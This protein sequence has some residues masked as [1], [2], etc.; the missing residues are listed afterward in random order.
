MS[1]QIE[2]SKEQINMWIRK[3]VP[4]KDFFFID[5]S[6]LTDLEEYLADVLLI[7]REEFFHHSSYKQIDLINSFMYWNISNKA[8]NVIVADS[9]WVTKLPLLKRKRILQAQSNMRRGLVL[10]I[11]SLSFTKSVPK[12]YVVSKNEEFFL[13]LQ[14]DMW[15][16]MSYELKESLLCSYAKRWDNGS[17][18]EVPE[19]TPLHI[20]K[21][22]NK[23]ST[24]SGSNCLSS[25]LFAVTKQD[26]V[27][28][29]WVHQKTFELALERVGYSLI[30]SVEGISNGDVITWVNPK[31]VIQHASYH[32]SNH[33][34]FNKDGQTFFNP[35][36]VTHLNQLIE[37]W[38]EY[39]M[40]IYRKKII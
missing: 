11:D 25:T 22:T 7:P 18:F 37:E 34:F 5:E 33:L 36:K 24:I 15:G 40:N 1:I 23:F 6:A 12:E 10:P 38:K 17:C 27:I 9:Q 31:N 28:K 29:E 14:Q 13:V 30:K 39:E 32:I 20:K 2:P 21:Y 3:F 16:N 8:N 26:W 19:D 35:W 4:D